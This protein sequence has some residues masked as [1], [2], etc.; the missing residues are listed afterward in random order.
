M[1]LTGK[2]SSNI[3]HLTTITDFCGIIS[4]ARRINITDIIDPSGLPTPVD[5]VERVH[6]DGQV[7]VSPPE[8]AFENMILESGVLSP[9]SLPSAKHSDEQ[10]W[11]PPT[12]WEDPRCTMDDPFW[13]PGNA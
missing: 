9:S 5:T 13:V 4:A 11:Q 7:D 1:L 8:T 10:V 6:Y 12:R 2:I 3:F